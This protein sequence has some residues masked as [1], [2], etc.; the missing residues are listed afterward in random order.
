MN[1]GLRIILGLV[2]LL[3]LVGVFWDIFRFR[4]NYFRGKTQKELKWNKKLSKS[5]KL[6]EPKADLALDLEPDLNMPLQV[7]KE[8]V[9]ALDR[10]A[11]SAQF[12]EGQLQL[13]LAEPIESTPTEVIVL[14][15]MARQPG[16][17]LG[18]RLLEAFNESHLYYG[19][20][21]IFHRH[22]NSDGS[23]KV[24]FSIASAIEPGFFDL[25]KMD[26]LITPGL[27]LFFAPQSRNQAIATFELMLRTAKLLAQRL[28]GEL[29]DED[30]RPLTL[31][32][33][34]KYRER[35]RHLYFEPA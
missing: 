33:I 29:R 9:Q 6:I 26:T 3:I 25:A 14:I 21:E 23:G 28:D 27:T 35:V 19:D 31:S 12:E 32:S 1:T 17:F 2:A 22:E 34:E 4:K 7:E 13:P 18:R 10:Q 30:R 20:M 5:T 16:V 24:L 11:S 8:G 15:V